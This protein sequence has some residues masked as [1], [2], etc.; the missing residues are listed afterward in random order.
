MKS[1]TIFVAGAVF[2]SAAL[3]TKYF[4][5][6]PKDLTSIKLRPTEVLTWNC[7]I[8]DHRPKTIMIFCGDGGA[9]L[10]KI[11][12]THWGQSG[13]QGTGFYYKNLCNPD[14]ADGRIVHAPVDVFLSNL[15]QRKGKF[16]LRTLGIT[17]S[18]GKDFPWG[19]S[20]NGFEWDVMD[21]IENTNLD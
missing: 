19:E 11:A 18:N 4:S 5:S 7:E 15:T 2:L 14:C 3:A 16:Y 13:A 12:W 8:P 10:D 6:E 1:R 17:S 21:F 20:G 9:Y